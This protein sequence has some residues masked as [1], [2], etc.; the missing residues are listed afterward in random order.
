MLK[1]FAIIYLIVSFI[2]L[3]V[4][5]TAEAAGWK[6]THISSMAQLKKS[7]I[8]LKKA[9]VQIPMTEQT[10]APISANGQAIYASLA[11]I[12]PAFLGSPYVPGGK[13]PTGFDCS[14]FIYYV[15]NEAGLNIIRKSSAGYYKDAAKVVEPQIGDLVFFKDT[16]ISGISHMGVYIRDNKF[17]HAGSRGVEIT[18]LDNSYWKSH[19]VDFRRFNSVTN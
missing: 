18:S 13:L 9:P 2:G 16:Y 11:S 14:G 3:I 12:A 19:F 10:A 17:I 8:F 5:P 15:H 4:T 6:K 7:A 1:K